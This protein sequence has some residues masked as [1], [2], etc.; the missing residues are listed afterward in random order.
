MVLTAMAAGAQQPP[1]SG[2]VGLPPD[3]KPIGLPPDPKPVTAPET[4]A[5]SPSPP[6][7][8]PLPRSPAPHRASPAAPARP[9]APPA[10]AATVGAAASSEITLPDVLAVELPRGAAAIGPNDLLLRRLL[11]DASSGARTVTWDLTR[12]LG[13]GPV[14]VTFSAWDGAPGSGKPAATRLARLWVLPFGMAPV[15]ISG[16]ENATGGNNAVHIVRDAGGMVHMVWQ[17]G[18]DGAG[19]TGPVYRRAGVGPDGAVQFDSEPIF[20][21]D[22]TPSEWNAYPAL[23]VQGRNVQLVWQGGGTARTRRVSPGPNGWV[24]GPVIDTGVKSAGRDVGDAIA[25]DDKGGLHLVTPSG[26]YAFSGDGGRTWKSDE[27]PRPP[28]AEI[29]TQSVTVDPGGTVHIAFSAPVKRADP[30]GGKQG[31]YWPL[32][33]IDRTAAGW[34]NA[35]DVLANA[36][37]WKEFHGPDDVLADWARIAADRQGGLHIAWH[38]T[39]LSRVFAHDTA[40]YAWKKPGGTWSAPVPLMLPDARRG[41]RYSF[42]PSLALDGDRA[43]ATV[44]YDIY[45]GADWLGFDSSLVSLKGGRM[46]APPRPMTQFVH[47]AIAAHSPTTA[48]GARFPAAAPTVFHAPGGRVWLD[49]LELMQSPFPPGGPNL[50]VYQRLDLGGNPG[51]P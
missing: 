50:V 30:P 13:V 8:A 16:D 39:A 35:A 19:R 46:D 6:K 4:A 37:G 9:P 26:V 3:P 25:F 34:V 15:G 22:A 38:G 33:T 5:T 1:D 36:P 31:G 21:A 42:A 32:R 17:S 7:P 43:F 29:K 27:I 41:I 14:Q 49:V 44:F 2:F 10:P 48:L 24:L 18:G 28:N 47:G 45:N 20:V 12:K 23:A 51:K 40:F 11:A